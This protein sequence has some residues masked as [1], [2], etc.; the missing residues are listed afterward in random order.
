MLIAILV[1]TTMSFLSFIFLVCFSAW[2]LYTGDKAHKEKK[3]W[4]AQNKTS[5][6]EKLI[7]QLK[8]LGLLNEES[9]KSIP[10]QDR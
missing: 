6:N 9:K 2:V 1:M 5:Q 4:E 7:L 8:E 10:E 3:K